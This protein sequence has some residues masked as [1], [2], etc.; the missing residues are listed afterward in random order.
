VR[1]GE[2]GQCKCE[3]GSPCGAPLFG[4]A[5]SC[6]GLPI[7]PGALP[8]LIVGQPQRPIYERHGRID[9]MSRNPGP[10]LSTKRFGCGIFERSFDGGMPGVES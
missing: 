4:V 1:R 9:S 3:K 6:V 7:G 5:L 8:A 2:K 10:S